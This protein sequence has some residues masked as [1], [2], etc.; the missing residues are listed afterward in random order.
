MIPTLATASDK[1]AHETR[2]HS[3]ASMTN[4][5]RGTPRSLLAEA[6]TGEAGEAKTEFEDAGR[7]TPTIEGT[8]TRRLTLVRRVR[9]QA[10]FRLARRSLAPPVDAVHS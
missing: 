1:D 10:S 3:V 4:T 2:A 6:K 5:L 9:R 8:C 7:Q